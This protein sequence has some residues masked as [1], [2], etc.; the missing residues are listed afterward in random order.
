M[1]SGRMYIVFFPVSNGLSLRDNKA[2]VDDDKEH[3]GSLYIYDFS[4]Q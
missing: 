3:P 4:L 2:H 1:P